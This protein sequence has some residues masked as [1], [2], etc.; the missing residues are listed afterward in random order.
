M[1]DIG[2]DFAVLS[3]VRGD[4]RHIADIMAKPGREMDEVDGNSMGVTELALRMNDFGDEWSYG[5]KQISKF[6]G[7]AVKALDKIE[8]AFD[9]IDDKL[10]KELEKSGKDSR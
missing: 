1:S 7:A 6:S 5:I 8:K 10:A 9:Q 4:L 2:I 3:K